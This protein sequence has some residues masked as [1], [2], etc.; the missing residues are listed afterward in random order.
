MIRKFRFSFRP[1]SPKCQLPLWDFVLLATKPMLAQ[2]C[3]DSQCCLET[4]ALAALVVVAMVLLV[5][6][7]VL[8]P[9][10][11]EVGIALAP[12]AAEAEEAPTAALI[13]LNVT[14]IIAALAASFWCFYLHPSGVKP[15]PQSTDLGGPAAGDGSDPG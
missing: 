7:V 1:T 13:A 15:S 8:A 12:A 4:S 11:I 10:A 9:A 3:W 14:V 5:A 6:S 2:W